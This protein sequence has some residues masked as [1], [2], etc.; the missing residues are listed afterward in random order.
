VATGEE[1]TSQIQTIPSECGCSR[2][3]AETAKVDL[4]WLLNAAFRVK[5]HQ[6][7]LSSEGG[8]LAIGDVSPE[9]GSAGDR[10]Q[11]G[12]VFAQLNGTSDSGHARARLNPVRH[13]RHD[14]GSQDHAEKW[15]LA[16]GPRRSGATR[17]SWLSGWTSPIP[18]KQRRRPSLQ[19]ADLGGNKGLRSS[20][21]STGTARIPERTSGR[22]TTASLKARRWTTPTRSRM[23]RS[24]SGWVSGTPQHTTKARSA[25]TA[26]RSPVPGTIRAAAATRLCRPRPRVPEAPPAELLAAAL[27]V[28]F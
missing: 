18:P 22:A 21:T 26:T 4:G 6:V 10:G 28:A 2:V 25:R 1:Q 12:V 19:H 9:P 24:P 17:T 8:R 7:R 15:T 27:R 11:A 13:V 20:V 14:G 16:P 3:A 23:T 5:S